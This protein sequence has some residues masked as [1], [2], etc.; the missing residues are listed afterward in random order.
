MS[1]WL[2]ELEL[3][4]CTGFI[5]NCKKRKKIAKYIFSSKEYN[6]HEDTPMHIHKQNENKLSKISSYQNLAIER[7]KKMLSFGYFTRDEIIAKRSKQMQD[8]L[9][10]V[11]KTDDSIYQNRK[12]H[13]C[14][15]ALGFSDYREIDFSAIKQ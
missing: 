13:N 8:L 10:F 2:T 3:W 6:L 7:E 12:K 11:V 9:D 4:N 14:E 15:L 5:A 1:N